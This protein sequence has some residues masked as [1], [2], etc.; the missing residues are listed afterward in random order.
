MILVNKDFN[1]KFPSD[2]H[3]SFHNARCEASRCKTRLGT[4]FTKIVQYWLSGNT[5]TNRRFQLEDLSVH[6]QR[7]SW[8][9]RM[10]QIVSGHQLRFQGVPKRSGATFATPKQLPKRMFW[11]NIFS[12]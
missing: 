4:L 5:T 7:Q 6:I 11:T 12:K 3:H 1:Q 2:L 9:L 10:S 8:V